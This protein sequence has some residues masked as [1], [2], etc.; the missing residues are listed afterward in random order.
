M[1]N[2]SRAIEDAIEK[3][4]KRIWTN[5]FIR[6]ISLA[7]LICGVSVMMLT[8]A[9]HL[10]VVMDIWL[11]ASV[12]SSVV[13]F[14][15]M[16]AGLLGRPSRKR[17]AEI[18]DDLGYCD[19]F[20]TYL[21][22][23][24]VD[25]P[26]MNYFIEEVEDKLYDVDLKKKYRLVFK[27]KRIFVSMA[28]FVA[29]AAVS[30]IP[31]HKSM[32]AEDIENIRKDI[33]DEAKK[34]AVIREDLEEEMEDSLGEYMLLREQIV[35]ELERLEKGFGNADSYDEIVDD[36]QSAQ[37]NMDMALEKNISDGLSNIS[38]IMDGVEGSY[39]ELKG[40]MSKGDIERTLELAK[41][42]EFSA[43]D[44]A[45]I[46]DNMKKQGKNLNAAARNMM[47]EIQSS[48]DEGNLT[49][50]KLADSIEKAVRET[51]SQLIEKTEMK[52]DNM[53][54]RIEAKSKGADIETGG[55]DA[56]D[57]YNIGENNIDG[58][59]EL[60]DESETTRTGTGDGYA[61]TGGGPDGKGGGN[62]DGSS[63]AGSSTIELLEEVSRLGDDEKDGTDNVSGTWQESGNVLEKNMAEAIAVLGEE[64][65]VVQ[66]YR[67]F[68]KNGMDYVYRY[69]IPLTDR[70]LVIDYFE[71]INGER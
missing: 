24:D 68:Q 57:D 41:R 27:W 2:Y 6:A 1:I 67:E 42:E 65:T 32:L 44:L 10:V 55:I 7:L 5:N 54:E 14:L 30:L 26:V 48:M 28:L 22:Y 69:E 21:Q 43:G 39:S 3:V 15:A 9:R 40:A 12:F 34:L 38:G 58:N 31:S 13:V 51:E 59:G 70:Q 50:E 19:R 16:A 53:K 37:K 56:V 45:R 4:R 23:G 71:I 29:A 35:N 18:M 11:K 66:S 25:N 46:E 52:I 60:S 8:L 17:T 36:L 63:T 64:S 61:Q 49:G 47:E 20:K 33:E 62:G